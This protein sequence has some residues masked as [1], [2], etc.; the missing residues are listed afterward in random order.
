MRAGSASRKLPRAGT[1]AL[2]TSRSMLGWR[3]STLSAAA[4]TDSRSATS[5][6]SCSSAA[7]GRRESPAT[8]VPRAC[9]WRTSSAPIPDEAPVTTATRTLLPAD[10]ELA[11]G[12]GLAARAVDDDSCEAMH[13]TLQ[14]ARVPGRGV[15][16]SGPG[17][18]DADAAAVVGEDDLR[19]LRRRPGDHEQ[20]FVLHG[21]HVRGRLDPGH[22]G[23]VHDRQPRL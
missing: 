18:V 10:A 23:P 12:R 6:S 3:A 13:A 22:G 2:L 9:N 21:A 4:S 7:D 16:A 20:A 19:H 1:P 8:R 17:L 11:T 5:H 14:L 15:H